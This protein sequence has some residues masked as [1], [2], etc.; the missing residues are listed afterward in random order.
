M[1]FYSG[2]RAEMFYPEPEPGPKRRKISR[3]LAE[4]CCELPMSKKKTDQVTPGEPI[5]LLPA[6]YIRNFYK[7]IEIAI[8]SV[9]NPHADPDPGS[10]KSA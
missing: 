2:A 4:D 1:R 7:Y 6:M 10:K 9:V 8:T 5:L 3:A